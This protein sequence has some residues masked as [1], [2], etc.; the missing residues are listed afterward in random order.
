MAEIIVPVDVTD[1][2]AKSLQDCSIDGL[3]VVDYTNLDNINKRIKCEV[4]ID[5]VDMLTDI[6][7]LD[8]YKLTP[9]V[10]AARIKYEDVLKKFITDK[11]QLE[12]ALDEM[13]PMFVPPGTKGGVRGRKFNDI[14]EAEIKSWVLP[15]TDF[16]IKFEEQHNDFKT[17]EIPDWFIYN[18]KTNKI[19][20]GMN[21]ITLWGGGA[22]NNRGSKYIHERKNTDICRLIAVVCNDVTIKSKKNKKYNLF[23]VGFAKN[24]LCYRNGLRAIVDEYFSIIT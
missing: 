8:K 16:V 6:N 24:T 3:I 18:N 14:V 22:Q 2:L 20:I 12:A 10:K 15:K 1:G 13:T 19:L 9:S 17:S 4:C 11:A 23:S 7:L 21:Q 5:T